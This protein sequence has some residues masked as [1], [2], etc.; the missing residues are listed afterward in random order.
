MNLSPFLSIKAIKIPNLNTKWAFFLSNRAKKLMREQYQNTQIYSKKLNWLKF[1]IYIFYF[2]RAEACPRRLAGNY[3]KCPL[4]YFEARSNRWGLSNMK[5]VLLLLTEEG[6]GEVQVLSFLVARIS[7]AGRRSVGLYRLIFPSRPFFGEWVSN[8]LWPPRPEVLC[9]NWS[10]VLNLTTAALLQLRP[11]PL[12][13]VGASPCVFCFLD[14]FFRGHLVW[15][16]PA[17]LAS[18]HCWRSF[19]QWRGEGE[20]LRRC[21]WG[22]FGTVCLLSGK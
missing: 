9:L 14:G 5:R 1:Y 20:V 12:Q 7:Y 2:R 18:W 21:K 11:L 15:L 17:E 13:R 6:E 4:R 22:E 10:P 3:Q 8:A 16:Q 19:W